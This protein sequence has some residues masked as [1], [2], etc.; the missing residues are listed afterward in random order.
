MSGHNKKI[1][2]QQRI[3][4]CQSGGK[5]NKQSNCANNIYDTKSNKKYQTESND[6]DMLS[7]CYGRGAFCL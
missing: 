4:G 1:S 2:S 6:Y 5:G 7:F 3:K